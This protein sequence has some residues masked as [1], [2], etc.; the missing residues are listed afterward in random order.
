MPTYIK[1]RIPIPAAAGHTS[2]MYTPARETSSRLSGPAGLCSI[3]FG[4]TWSTSTSRFVGTMVPATKE[5]TEDLLG[6]LVNANPDVIDDPKAYGFQ[7]SNRLSAWSK[8]GRD[9]AA[10]R[11]S[12]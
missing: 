9:F 3:E 2:G 12:K 8:A 5:E 4:Y 10:H 7:T 1:S 6:R 11:R